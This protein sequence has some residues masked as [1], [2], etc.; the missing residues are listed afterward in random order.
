MQGYFEPLLA[1]GA[2]EGIIVGDVDLETAV[3]AF[4]RSVGALPARPATS[5]AQSDLRVQPP[6]PSRTP[7]TFTHTGDKDQAFAVIGW[8]TFGGMDRHRERRALGL[9]ANMFR[10]RLFDRFREEEGAS[11]SPSAISTTSEEL[12]DWGVFYAA[13]ELKPES[14]EA[15]FRAARE[16]VADLASKPVSAE[17][18]ERAKNPVVSGIGRQ[19]KTNSYWL[20]EME[21]W[22]TDPKRMER[23]RSFLSDYTGMTAEE[24]RAAVAKHVA[25]AGDWS[26]LVLPAN[27]AGGGN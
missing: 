6:Q 24:V 23:T 3:A 13:S 16:I 5:L 12:K 10:V 15:F 20:S 27:K 9:A 17:E 4:A 18:F 14:A 2:I 8:T 7:K 11:Y 26:M 19:L 21:G 22:S 1:Q 25:D